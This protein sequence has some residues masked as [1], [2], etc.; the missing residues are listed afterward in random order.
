[1]ALLT[2][3]DALYFG[4]HP[5][6][7]T[8]LGG[9][10]VWREQGEILIFGND[11]AT[12]SGTSSSSNDRA[13]ASPFVKAQ[14]GEII[15]MWAFCTAA[16]AP[17]TDAKFIIMADDAGAPGDVLCVSTGS[18]MVSGWIEFP[19]PAE[20]SAAFAAGTYWLGV[21]ADNFTGVWGRRDFIGDAVLANGTFPYASPPASWP[22]TDASYTGEL[23]FYCEYESDE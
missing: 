5:S 17:G 11:Q 10:R 4:T 8:Y 7:V 21:V 9:S 16:T 15:S 23:Y 6:A 20:A 14:D 12:E 19:V 3:A 18:S 2:G 13:V 1:M 22:G